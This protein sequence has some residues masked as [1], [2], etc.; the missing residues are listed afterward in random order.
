MFEQVRKSSGKITMAGLLEVQD[1]P[2]LVLYNTG[3]MLSYYGDLHLRLID[4][5]RFCF[6]PAGFFDKEHKIF[7]VQPGR[8]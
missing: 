8:R 1:F 6:E 7:S 5:K 4:L 2:T 3:V